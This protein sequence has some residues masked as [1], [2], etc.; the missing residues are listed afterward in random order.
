MKIFIKYSFIFLS[1]LLLLPP[2]VSFTHLFS[3]S[4]SEIYRIF[5]DIHPHEETTDYLFF[6]SQMSSP[7]FLA[8][9]HTNFDH[10]PLAKNIFFDHYSS[11]SEHLVISTE[12]RGPPL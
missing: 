11:L 9:V 10:T 1:L 4:I 12:H 8:P 7:P 2:P 6:D 3:N 5:Q